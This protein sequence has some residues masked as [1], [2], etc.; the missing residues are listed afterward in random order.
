M[1]HSR[2]RPRARRA[3]IAAAAAVLLP[4]ALEVSAAP[5]AGAAGEAIQFEMAAATAAQAPRDLPIGRDSKRALLA[6]LS[7]PEARPV[8]ALEARPVAY[9]PTGHWQL[10]AVGT[11]AS[12]GLTLALVLGRRQQRFALLRARPRAFSR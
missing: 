1:C 11:A 2:E 9:L 3:P 4:V 8:A 5:A 10:T 12:L 7:T 6:N